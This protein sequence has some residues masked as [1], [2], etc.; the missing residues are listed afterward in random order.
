[1]DP[2]LIAESVK[3]MSDSQYYALKQIS[4]QHRVPFTS[5]VKQYHDEVIAP[6]HAAVAAEPAEADKA[7][8][9]DKANVADE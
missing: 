4:E 8:E 2:H 6:E 7:P 1:M 5:L 3:T 9:A